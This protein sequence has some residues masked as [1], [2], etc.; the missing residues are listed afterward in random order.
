MSVKK[1]EEL[2]QALREQRKHPTPAPTQPPTKAPS[3]NWVVNTWN[4]AVD[5]T[6]Q[7]YTTVKNKITGGEKKDPRDLD[8]LTEEQ[9]RVFLLCDLCSCSAACVPCVSF[10]LLRLIMQQQQVK[11]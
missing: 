2:R 4:K 7:L 6:K 3:N 1:Q 11:D 5:K 10:L 9:I 8:L